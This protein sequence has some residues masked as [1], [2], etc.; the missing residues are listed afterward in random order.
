MA[1]MLLAADYCV[2]NSDVDDLR[3][4]LAAEQVERCDFVA[5]SSGAATAWVFTLRHPQRVRRLD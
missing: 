3:L 1:A 2:G 5:H 4:L